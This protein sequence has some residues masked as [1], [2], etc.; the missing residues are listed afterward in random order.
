MP[1]RSGHRRLRG[2]VGQSAE[3]CGHGGLEVEAVIRGAHIM[4]RIPE[5]SL[6]EGHLALLARI[7]GQR[8]LEVDH[9][10]LVGATGRGDGHFRIKDKGGLHQGAVKYFTAPW[11]PLF[12]A[13]ILRNR[14]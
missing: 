8:W 3:R 13:V 12:L 14:I 1:G 4:P 2:A 10:V 5:G 11:S 6:N 9:E 7:Q